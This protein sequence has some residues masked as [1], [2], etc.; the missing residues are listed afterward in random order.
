MSLSKSHGPTTGRGT[1]SVAAAPLADPPTQEN[2]TITESKKK[3]NASVAI[4]IQIPL[5]RRSGSDSSAADDR[6][7]DGADQRAD[8]D[9][10]VEA[11]DELEDGEASDR[12]ERALGQRDVAA[13]AGHHGDRQEHDRQDDRLG[14]EEDPDGVAAGEQDDA[15]GDEERG[16]EQ[17]A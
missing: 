5:S 1:G 9:R 16:A 14:D 10:H 8:E 2:L 3:A 4:A 11:V 13:E 7:D 12:R 15:A 6:R 17:A